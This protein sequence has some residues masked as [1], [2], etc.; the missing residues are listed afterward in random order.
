MADNALTKK[1]KKKPTRR[2]VV[3]RINQKLKQQAIDDAMGLVGGL[4][5][6]G[7]IGSA[8]IAEPLSGLAG[9]AGSVLPGKAGQGGRWVEGVQNALTYQPRSDE[10]QA[11][12]Q[13]ISDSIVG[14]F[15]EGFQEAEQNLGNYVLDKTGSPL[16]ATAAHSLPT[17]AM[18]ALGVMPFTK[19]AKNAAKGSHGTTRIFAGVGS[20]TADLSRLDKAKKMAK[21]GSSR[22]EIWDITGWFE[23]VDGKWKYEIPDDDYFLKANKLEADFDYPEISYAQMDD[24]VKHD[25]LFD[26]Y[27][28][29]REGTIEVNPNISAEGTYKPVL[30]HDVIQLKGQDKV[31]QLERLK[32]AEA[33]TEDWAKA[34]FDAGEFPTYEDALAFHKE[35]LAM[36][37][38]EFNRALTPQNKSTGI[39]E[40]QHAIQERE[41]F[42]RGGNPEVGNYEK[43]LSNLEYYKGEAEAARKAARNTPEY[44]DIQSQIDEAL[45]KGDMDTV[46]ELVPQ[47]RGLED[48][49]AKD[50]DME[51]AALSEKVKLTPRE[52]YQRLAGEAEARNV[53]TRMNMTPEERAAQ[54][55]WTTLDVPEDELI[56]RN[57]LAGE[58]AS[59]DDS[60]MKKRGSQ[61]TEKA[62][63]ADALWELKYEPLIAK[64]LKEHG[65]GYD[66]SK[67]RRSLGADF[68]NEVK[69]L[70][71]HEMAADGRKLGLMDDDGKII[72]TFDNFDDLDDAAYEYGGEVVSIDSSGKA[73]SFEGV[74]SAPAQYTADDLGSMLERFEK[75]N[76]KSKMSV[77]PTKNALSGDE[78][79]KRRKKK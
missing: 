56:V 12:M 37:A 2:E 17:A 31:G 16:L 59:V 22:D 61:I 72:G 30:G 24:T 75:I 9:I 53:Q 33:N 63:S 78:L 43:N 28:H 5:T 60:F 3:A 70:K 47:R 18:E 57:A 67:A 29:L 68:K 27:P 1:A 14:R 73:A 52:E 21:A 23:D 66:Y 49:A 15:G 45:A 26:A 41:G 46:K 20:N 13:G 4:E 19:V 71:L 64:A 55:P 10:G 48:A 39:H 62:M 74:P 6:A 11:N 34:D 54:A 44:I 7:T 38:D 8:I 40:L 35:Q 76:Q 79:S 69:A 50:F 42:A 32:Y 77:V 58:A 36:E 65:E 25:E 51:A